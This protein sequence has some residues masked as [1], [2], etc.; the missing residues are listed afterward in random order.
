MDY[1]AFD[2][3]TNTVWV[4]A[5]NT[6]SVDVVDDATGK[7][8]RIEGF[9]TQEME[10]RGHKRI[11]GPSSV[12]LGA[13]GTVYVGNRGDF[14]ICAID[15]KTLKKGTCGKI[16]SMPDGIAYVA[17]TKEVWVTTPRDKTIRILD[18]TTLAQKAKLTFE[19][20]PEGFAADP[21][22]GRFYTNLEDKDATL[23]IDLKTH[24]TVATWQPKCGEDGPHG[25]R[26]DESNGLLVIAC[27]AKV[28]AMDVKTGA[29]TGSVDT[30]DGV[31]DI[32]FLAG[33]VYVGAAKAAKL[34]IASLDAK[35]TMAVVA[36][37]PTADGAR[38]GVV[39]TAGKVYLSHSTGSELVVVSSA[40]Q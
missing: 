17:P 27:S 30:G 40:G 36:T 10:R 28:E 4:P 7:I 1:L 24:K 35:G 11:V 21:T 20:E 13:P 38:N 15:E 32:D 2:P 33:R 18:A 23:A 16:D 26:L 31:D 9:T 3:R 37:M 14:S 34:T 6:G 12:T 29:I 39:T 25:L 5:G 8:Q 22:R 19:G